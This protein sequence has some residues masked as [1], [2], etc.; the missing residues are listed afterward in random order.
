MMEASALAPS[1]WPKF[2]LIEPISRRS[3]GAFCYGAKQRTVTE[4][5]GLLNEADPRYVIRKVHDQGALGLLE[6]YL[7]RGHGVNNVSH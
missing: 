4:F 6:I 3:S 5:E 2:G 7:D 1:V